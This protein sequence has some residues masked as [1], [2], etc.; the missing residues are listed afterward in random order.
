M[1][2]EI[3]LLRHYRNETSGPSGDAWDRARSAIA[4]AQAG[5]APARRGH[6]RGRRR[7]PIAAGA[8]A[9]VLAAAAVIFVVR[10]Q[11]PEPAAAGPVGDRAS[12]PAR[13]K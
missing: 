13:G 6:A 2:D 8:I 1:I 11:F 5:S 12:D 7:R 9:V 4:A 3:E 10:H